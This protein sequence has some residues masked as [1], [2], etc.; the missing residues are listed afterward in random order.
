MTIRTAI[1]GFGTAGRVFHAPFIAAD[2]HYELSAVVTRDEGRRAEVAAR[3][4]SARVLPDVDALLA[5]AAEVD[6]VVIGSPSGTHAELADALLD[7][8]V[9]VV[10]DKPF[11]V[12]AAEGRALVEKSER[13]GQPLT[14]FHNR[15]WDGDFRTLRGLM[16][17]G[18]LGEVWR[19]ESRF[20][21]WK[22]DRDDSWKT[23]ATTAEGGGI[24][25]DLGAHLLDQAL[26][27]FATPCRY[28]ARWPPAGRARRPTRTPSWCC[29][30]TRGCTRTCG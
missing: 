2:P 6:L 29:G 14:V 23:T 11:S 22:P 9:G 15:R 19:F 26:L 4:P 5:S 7:A 24:L 16:E 20:E 18:E 17:R 8:G 21:W 27:L 12:T 13:L 3:Y 25:Y 30:T 10:V 28:T 1:I